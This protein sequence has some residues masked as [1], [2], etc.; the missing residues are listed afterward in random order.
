MTGDV[1]Q[2]ITLGAVI[3]GVVVNVSGLMTKRDAQVTADAR[4]DVKLDTI[5]EK[6]GKIDTHQERTDKTLA[7]HEGRIIKVEECAKT[8][9]ERLKELCVEHKEKCGGIIHA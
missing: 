9:E 7:D 8:T 4:R 1:L 2:A 5:L 3:L 6:V